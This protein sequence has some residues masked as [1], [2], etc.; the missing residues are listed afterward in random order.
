MVR[1]LF[2]ED[3]DPAASFVNIR[4]GRSLKAVSSNAGCSNQGTSCSGTNTS[5]CTNFVD[6]SKG[7]NTPDTTCVNI[8]C[9]D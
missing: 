9:G 7:T 8:L 1:S 4:G 6:C 2:R 3:G 5:G